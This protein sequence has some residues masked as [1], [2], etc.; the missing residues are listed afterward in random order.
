MDQ[1]LK[2]AKANLGEATENIKDLISNQFDATKSHIEGHVEGMSDATKGAV[3]DMAKSVQKKAD[4]V[5][6]KLSK[7][8]EPVVKI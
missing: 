6:E 3:L 4:A 7:P 2:K 1:N 8:E 5:V